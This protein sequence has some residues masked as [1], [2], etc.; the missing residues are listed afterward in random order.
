MFTTCKAKIGITQHQ[1]LHDRHDGLR[2]RPAQP[3]DVHRGRRLW[4]ARLH[5][6][7]AAKVHVA[8]FGVDDMAKGDM[9][10]LRAFHAGAFQ[11]GLGDGGTK[12]DG[13]RS[14]QRA[15]ESADG[16]AGAAENDDI[17]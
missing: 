17:V 3:V 5:R 16:G 13:G 6:G 8:R 11:R 4:H 9:A 10:D 12:V 7:D 2:A 14:G 15:A 1:G